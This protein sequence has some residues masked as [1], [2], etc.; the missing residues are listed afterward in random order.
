MRPMPP[1]AMFSY[2]TVTLVIFLSTNSRVVPIAA[3]TPVL[4]LKH[5]LPTNHCRPIR[6]HQQFRHQMRGFQL[7]YTTDSVLLLQ[8][9]RILA[10]N[11]ASRSG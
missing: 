9:R 8:V 10:L 6:T 7:F 11:A 3:N 2:V 1:S 5:A 4:T